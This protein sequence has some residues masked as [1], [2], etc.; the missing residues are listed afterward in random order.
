[1][2]VANAEN[3]NTVESVDEIVGQRPV[4]RKELVSSAASGGPSILLV[5]FAPGSRLNYH[6]HDYEQILIITEGT[7]IVGTKKEEKTVK[8]GDVVFFAPGE[9]HWHGA[10]KTSSLSHIC[11]QRPGIHLAE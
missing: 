8:P 9:V 4:Y 7:G 1:M 11:I 10:T 5:T 2:I 6:T 3:L